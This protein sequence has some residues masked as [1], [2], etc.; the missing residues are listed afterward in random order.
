MIGNTF[1]CTYLKDARTSVRIFDLAGSHL[2]DVELPGIGSAFG[3]FMARGR[4]PPRVL[5][6]GCQLLLVAALAWAATAV[7]DSTRP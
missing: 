1:V 6:G 2:R 5:W 4:I 3:S 7:S